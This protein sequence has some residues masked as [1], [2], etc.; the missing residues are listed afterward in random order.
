MCRPEDEPDN[1]VSLDRRSRALNWQGKGNDPSLQYKCQGYSGVK[2]GAKLG[3]A[4][5][6][7][8]SSS[9]TWSLWIGYS[10]K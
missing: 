8:T 6:G 1:I 3:Y 5:A 10:S 9:S 2:S 4:G 7:N